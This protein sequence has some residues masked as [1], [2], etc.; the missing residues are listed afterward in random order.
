MSNAE[1]NELKQKYV[2]AGAASPATAFADRAENAEIWDA[3][4]NRFIDFA[5]GIGVLN[6]G[7]RHPK[8]VAAVKAQLDKVMHTCQTVMPYEGYVKVAEKLSHIVPVRGHAKV[9]LANSGAEALENAVKIARAA[10]GRSNVICFDGGYHGRTFYT[11]AMNGKVAPYQTDFGPMPGTVFRAPYPVPY[12]GVSE[13]EA[14]R[15]LKMTLKTDANPKDTA[16]I[17]LEPVLGEGGFYPAPTSF[18]KKIREICDEHGMLMIIDE[19][20][21]GFGRTGKMFAIEHSGVE[22]DMM[23]MAKSM[24]DGMPISAIVGTDKVM[25][26]SGPNSLGGTYTGS[27]TACAAALAVMEVF[28]E[29][30]ILEKS[31]ALGDK[32]AAR[33]NEW[34][35][36]FDCIDHVRNMGAMAAF[37]LVN[38]KTD[39]TPNPELAAAL[40]KKAREEGLILLSCGMYGNTIRFLMPV[41]IEDDVLNEGLD[42][43][44]S[45][46][47]SL[48]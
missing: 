5:G 11:M 37:E 46:L 25:D 9:M 4:G 8:V 43:I 27:P 28:E 3:D 47:E 44:E 32:L 20:Q 2:A 21:S 26:A 19:V 31:Q 48:I 38:N 14:I 12:H 24:A 36:K 45:C 22:P 30:N 29:E 40:C 16:A 18:L 1:L 42:I 39:R 17:I 34:Q 7:H 6:V 13:D 33:F 15:G 23:T 35:G 41:T 10:T